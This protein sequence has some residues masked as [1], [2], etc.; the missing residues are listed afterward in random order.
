[1]GALWEPYGMPLGAYVSP[2]GDTHSSPRNN[3]SLAPHGSHM[4]AIWV[5]MGALWGAYNNPMVALRATPIHPIEIMVPL[6]HMLWMSYGV[7]IAALWEP[8]GHY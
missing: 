8:R 4:K 7:P 1:M 2:V 3:G 6:R 5:P